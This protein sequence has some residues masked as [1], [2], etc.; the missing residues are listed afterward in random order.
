MYRKVTLLF[1]VGES[2]KKRKKM[3]EKYLNENFVD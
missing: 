3:K 1:R 2:F